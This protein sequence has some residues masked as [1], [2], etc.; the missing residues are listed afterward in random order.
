VK[1]GSLFSGIGGLELGLERAGLGQVVWQIE[2][3]PAR[4][5]VLEKHWPAA[6]RYEDVR[7]KYELEKV[8]IL[9]GGFP[10]QDVS[11]ASRGRGGGIA[12][13]RSGLWKEYARVVEQIKPQWV[14]VE[15]VAGAAARKW[16]P[17]VRRDLHMLGYRT[18]ALRVDARDVGASHARPRIFVIG[19]PYTKSQPARSFD[20]QVARMQKTSGLGRYWWK[21][22]PRILRMADGVSGGLDR[23]RMLGDAVVPQC[24]ELVGL[25]LTKMM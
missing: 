18:R 12:G 11:D 8:D 6:K 5:R 21:P 15:N 14:I 1:I 22:K 10:C 19:D 16:L 17:T 9:C 4:R 24:G 13:E 7:Q 20:A 3:D 25:L 2:I 23:V